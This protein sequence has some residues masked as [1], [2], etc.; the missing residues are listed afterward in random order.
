MAW[1]SAFRSW[2][3]WCLPSAWSSLSWSN[4]HR[5]LVAPEQRRTRHGSMALTPRGSSPWGSSRCVPWKGEGRSLVFVFYCLGSCCS[6][7]ACMLLL[8]LREK[9]SSPWLRDSKTTMG[10]ETPCF[11][12]RISDLSLHLVG[13]LRFFSCDPFQH[14]WLSMWS[15]RANC[16]PGGWYGLLALPM[17]PGYG[18]VAVSFLDLVGDLWNSFHVQLG[19]LEGFRSQH[20]EGSFPFARKNDPSAVVER[21]SFAFGSHCSDGFRYQRQTQR[22]EGFCRW[23][24]FLLRGFQCDSITSIL[25]FLWLDCLPIE[26]LFSN[27]RSLHGIEQVAINHQ[28]RKLSKTRGN[29]KLSNSSSH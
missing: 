1:L 11:R 27:T 4:W 26:Q 5:T 19:N 29:H 9:T 2:R 8:G 24:C 14:H 25:F 17:H 22:G 13:P 7:Y 23:L 16:G 3:L 12:W 21:K 6:G 10:S 28:T 15:R 20:H 18:L